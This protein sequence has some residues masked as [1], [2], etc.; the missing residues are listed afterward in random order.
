MSSNYI[1][2]LGWNSPRAVNKKGN[3]QVQQARE[4]PF[5]LAACI[6]STRTIQLFLFEGKRCIRCLNSEKVV[7]TGLALKQAHEEKH[8]SIFS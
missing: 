5:S 2:D 4:S 3:L 1:W 6:C 7:N 8:K